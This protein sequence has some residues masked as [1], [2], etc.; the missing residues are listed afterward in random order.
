MSHCSEKPIEI[1]IIK[2]QNYKDEISL[3]NLV[4]ELWAGKFIILG[5]T[6]LGLVLSS[7]FIIKTKEEWTSKAVITEASLNEVYNLAQAFENVL[8]KSSEGVTSEL[9]SRLVTQMQIESLRR[10]DLKL[11]HLRGRKDII[12]VSYMASS[13]LSAQKNLQTFLD[14]INK[15]VLDEQRRNL[16]ALKKV[17]S[18]K[19]KYVIDTFK[20]RS[21]ESSEYYHALSVFS[22]LNNTSLDFSEESLFKVVYGPDL[23]ETRGAPQTKLITLFGVISG[24]FLGSLIVLIRGLFLKENKG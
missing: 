8:D 21:K 16:S 4:S 13:A 19:A 7:A 2:D 17:K 18:D 20:G 6:L 10:P 3:A 15:Q 9:F 24:F 22:L 23:P 11:D 12:E 5:V 14:N 1:K